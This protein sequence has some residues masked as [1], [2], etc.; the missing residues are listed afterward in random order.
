MDEGQTLSKEAMSVLM[1][2]VQSIILACRAKQSYLVLVDGTEVGL[3]VRV[4]VCVCAYMCV[5]VGGR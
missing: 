1:D 3:C 4:C 5:C 2:H